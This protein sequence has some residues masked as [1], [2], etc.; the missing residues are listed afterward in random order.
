MNVK[1]GGRKLGRWRW[2]D[3]TVSNGCVPMVMTG[4]RI[5]KSMKATTMLIM[6]RLMGIEPASLRA[7]RL[8]LSSCS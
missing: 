2:H 6:M 7:F 4:R 1:V 5:I 8:G 3:K